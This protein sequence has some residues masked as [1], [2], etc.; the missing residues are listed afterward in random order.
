MFKMN[1]RQKLIFYVH[2][3]TVPTQRAAPKRNLFFHSYNAEL[4][5][6]F[7]AHLQYKE[8]FPNETLQSEYDVTE[9]I[10]RTQATHNIKATFYWVKGHQDKNKTYEELPLEA[11]LN[12]NADELA[13]E[14]QDEYGKFR[15]LVHLLP[16]CPAMLAIRG[17]SITGNYRKQLIRAYVE[18]L[19]IQCTCNI[20]FSG[21]TTL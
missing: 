16:S 6:R 19:Y 5:R 3:G 10:Y 12:I 17:I 4:I 11:Q 8:P 21:P 13:G 1:F 15:P 14:Y 9:Q 18:P 7:R 20:N 2:P